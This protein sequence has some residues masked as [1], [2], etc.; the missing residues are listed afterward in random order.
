MPLFV[1]PVSVIIDRSDLD[2]ATEVD[3]LPIC[4][5]EELVVCIYSVVSGE[6]QENLANMKGSNEVF[7]AVEDVFGL[8]EN[9]RVRQLA[10]KGVVNSI[11]L[12]S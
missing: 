1:A 8:V 6:D 9:S 12:V 3:N 7:H 4:E 2:K 5:L 11:A 10:K